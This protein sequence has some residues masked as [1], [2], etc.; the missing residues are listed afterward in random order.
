MKNVCTLLL[1]WAFSASSWAQSYFIN[2]VDY[3]GG[4]QG[5]EIAGSD[6]TDLSNASLVFYKVDGTIYKID[7]L[8]GTIPT[9]GGQ[10]GTV[11]YDVAMT[12]PGEATDGGSVALVDQSGQVINFITYGLSVGVTA[13][14]GAAVG[15]TAELIGPQLLPDAT[16]Q[17]IGRGLT[18]ADFIWSLPGLGT[19]GLPNLDQTFSGLLAGLSGISPERTSASVQI[20]PNPTQGQVRV[21]LGQHQSAGRLEV[22]LTDL[23]G[24]VL[25]RAVTHPASV[26]EWSLAQLPKGMYIVRIQQDEKLVEQHKLVKS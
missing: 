14:E 15:Q 3:L 10:N 6:G 12:D 5:L 26:I 7:Y 20:W 24:R 9:L 23:S 19:P 16:L 25:Q 11:W 18:Y 2:E 13:V 17:L 21:E 4:R 22:Q 8:N 1:L